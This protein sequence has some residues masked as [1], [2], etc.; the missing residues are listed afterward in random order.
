M[1]QP[2]IASTSAPQLE[3]QPAEIVFPPGNLWSD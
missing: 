3:T 2:V 1:A